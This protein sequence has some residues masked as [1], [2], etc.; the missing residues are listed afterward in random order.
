MASALLL[1]AFLTLRLQLA[2]ASALQ[3]HLAV[4]FQLAANRQIVAHPTDDRETLCGMVVI[5]KTPADDPKFLMPSR[6]T[7]VAI[8]RIE[9]H[10]CGAKTTVPPK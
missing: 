8:R 2:P 4:R 3:P 10:G 1:S 7:G 6:D 9:P 5:H